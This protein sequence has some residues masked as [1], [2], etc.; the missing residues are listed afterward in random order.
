MLF[1]FFNTGIVKPQTSMGTKIISHLE[2][3]HLDSMSK[4][5]I[6]SDTAHFE[7]PNWH[8]DGKHLVFNRDGLL[9]SLPIE[10]GEP[11]KINTGQLKNLNNDHVISPG[12]SHIGVSNNDPSLNY[13]SVIYA[14]PF[15]GG[16]PLRITPNAP[17]Y[18]HGWS[19][20]G[21]TLAFTGKRDG[22]F[23]IYTIDIKTMEEKRLTTAKGLDD[24][25]DYSPDG[26]YIWF[27]SER[28]DTMQIYR[29]LSNGEN[30]EQMT[31]DGYND[32]FP[33]PSPDGKYI[34]FLSY[35]EMVEGHP[36][37]KTVWLRMIP[38][39]GGEPV[40]LTELFGGQGTLN[41]PSWAPDSRKFAF[42]SYEILK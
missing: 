24:G 25:P 29:M 5:V 32:W 26:K 37:N 31:F 2:I 42:V 36:A 14:V 17:S 10:G 20:D 41:V 21:F 35:D 12:G 13:Q 27:N 38:A 39:E 28:T 1:L 23:D 15:S 30:Q 4:K 33:H 11:K 16:L 18:L 8:P 3:F 19:P 6:Y 9:Y 22:A 40:V 34:V 7:A